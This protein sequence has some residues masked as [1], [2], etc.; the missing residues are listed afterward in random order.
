MSEAPRRGRFARGLAIAYVVGLLLVIMTFRFVGERN[1]LVTV[2]LYL[3]R[4][5]FLLPLPFVLGALLVSGERTYAAVVAVVSCYLVLFPLMGYQL[6]GHA[7][8]APSS[9]RL[10]TW[11]TF[12]GR[13]DNEAIKRKVMEEQPDIFV[14]Q[15]SGHR[16]KE[17]FR[18]DAGGYTLEID[19]EFIL[20]T[21]FHVVEKDLPAPFPDDTNHRPNYVR[22]T[23]DTPFGLIDLFS[24]HPRSPR[25]GLDE[26]RG[27]G[28]KSRILE[29]DA[30]DPGESIDRNTRLRRRQVDAL[31]AAMREAKHPII[32]AGDT[33]LPVLSWLYHHAF[34]DMRD[35]FSEVGRGFGYTFPAKRPWLR[36]DR[37][38]ADRSFRFLRFWTG[39][40]IASDHHYVVADLTR[41]SP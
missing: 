29:A 18:A 7:T 21:R 40:M 41:A 1:W 19:D 23:L 27:H 26:F 15:A 24:V 35:G 9:F 36:I 12:Q 33:N 17:L 30:P 31:L 5:G 39:T 11:N 13:I 14:S 32:V 3:P 2:A 20:A 8:S 4:V 22:Y 34:G 16:T 25:S 28:F 10:M 38:L 6:V 37:I